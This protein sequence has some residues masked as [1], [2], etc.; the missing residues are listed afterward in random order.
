VRR[1]PG[2]RYHILDVGTACSRTHLCFELLVRTGAGSRSQE[3]SETEPQQ[4]C[5]LL[6]G[7]A[8]LG[9]FR[10]HSYPVPLRAKQPPV[11]FEVVCCGEPRSPLRSEVI[12]T[13]RSKGSSAPR[14]TRTD[15]AA[16]GTGRD[17]SLA[18]RLRMISRLMVSP[19]AW[20]EGDDRRG[21]LALRGTPPG[22]GC[23]R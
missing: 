20:F 7:M 22:R 5:Q 2:L 16:P 23:E 3:E 18:L 14:T 4:K 13:C 9:G 12:L 8:F 17:R 1:F 19:R 15:S 6:H 21:C 10:L 11:M